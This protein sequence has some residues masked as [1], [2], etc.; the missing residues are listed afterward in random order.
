MLREALLDQVHLGRAPPH[1]ADA[2]VRRA[3]AEQHGGRRA[4]EAEREEQVDD[5]EE[6]EQPAGAV[7][8]EVGGEAVEA[9]VRAERV[10][11]EDEAGGGD[12]DHPRGGEHG[13]HAAARRLPLQ[14]PFEERAQLQEGGE[15]DDGRPAEGGD[16]YAER[17]EGDD[18]ARGAADLLGPPEGSEV[19]GEVHGRQHEVR[20]ED[21]ER[22]AQHLWPER[23]RSALRSLRRGE[24]AAVLW[25]VSKGGAPGS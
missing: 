23:G 25:G 9:A 17:E 19:E 5:E 3:V 7:E 1:A 2:A 12:A 8:G 10:P 14:L 13:H 22:G 18:V 4:V 16:H 20:N 6:H 15:R 24:Q 21:R 11:C